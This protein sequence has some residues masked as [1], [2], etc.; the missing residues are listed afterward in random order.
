MKTFL[1]NYLPF[2]I[3]FL[4]TFSPFL[5]ATP[6]TLLPQIR[7]YI[8]S[9]QKEIDQIPEPRKQ[10][11][12]KIALFVQTKL[13]AHEP[14]QLIFICTHNSRRSHTAQ[15]WAQ[16]LAAYYGLQGV[17]AF[18]AGT[19]VTAFN[20]RAVKALQRAGFTIA[21]TTDSSN[22]MYAIQYASDTEPIKTFSKLLNDTANPQSNFCA[23][24]NCSQAEKTCP[25]VLGAAL[26]VSTPYDDPKDFDGTPQESE[27]YDECCRQIAREM[28]Y[29]F[30]QI[31]AQ[32]R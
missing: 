29:L 16:T 14:A 13:A 21:A 17:K 27:K 19:E 10:Q 23:V 3:V 4:T 22:P 12:K 1:I 31:H 25:M 15:I 9:R 20:D 18:S 7:L 5:L 30:S 32:K 26:R 2:L 6:S 11:L 24:M 8:E 28:T